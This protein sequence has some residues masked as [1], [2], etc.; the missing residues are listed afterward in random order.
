MGLDESLS[1]QTHQRIK[2]LLSGVFNRA[3]QG[4][5]RLPIPRYAAQSLG[6]R[7]RLDFLGDSLRLCMF[8]TRSDI[9]TSARHSWVW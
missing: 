8:C 5:E 2:A 6:T 4:C 7:Q 3:K 9:C 1:H